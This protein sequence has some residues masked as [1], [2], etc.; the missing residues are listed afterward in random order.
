MRGLELRTGHGAF[1]IQVPLEPVVLMGNFRAEMCEIEVPM[2]TRGITSRNAH[3]T[4]SDWHFTTKDARI[5]RKHLYP[6][7]T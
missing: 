6:S 5:K 1:A 3:H 4:K 7:T 2:A